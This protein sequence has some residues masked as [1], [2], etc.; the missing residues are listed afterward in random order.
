MRKNQKP[1]LLLALIVAQ[2]F[3]FVNTN[4]VI[5]CF[6]NGFIP[7]YYQLYTSCAAGI[8]GYLQ[9]RDDLLIQFSIAFV[10]Y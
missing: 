5:S 10:S 2:I 9:K 8:E 4:Y 7:L 6:C 3:R 1:P